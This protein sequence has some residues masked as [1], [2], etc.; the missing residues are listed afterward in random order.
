MDLM[1]ILCLW[2]S[3]LA[4]I[5]FAVLLVFAALSAEV[6]EGRVITL[7]VAGFLTVV[8]LWMVPEVAGDSTKQ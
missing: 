4:I 5:V 6:S 2:G 1:K 8:G 7:F 3:I